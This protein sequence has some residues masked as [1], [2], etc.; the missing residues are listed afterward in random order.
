[1]MTGCLGQ[2]NY[3]SQYVDLAHH[4]QGATRILLGLSVMNRVTGAVKSTLRFLLLNLLNFIFIIS[5]TCIILVTWDRIGFLELTQE[6]ASLIF[7]AITVQIGIALTVMR[8]TWQAFRKVS[9]GIPRGQ[10]RLRTNLKAEDNPTIK[11]RA[12]ILWFLGFGTIFF[13][14]SI[15][16]HLFTLMGIGSVILQ[17]KPGPYTVENYRW[18]IFMAEWGSLFFIFGFFWSGYIYYVKEVFNFLA[19]RQS[20][21]FPDSHDA[22]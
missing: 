4:H 11:S 5:L 21:L 3:Q 22:T 12:I 1:M 2:Y 17:L 18:G 7:A 6:S 14:A 20:L 10:R 13:G 15:F 16:C 9:D 19:G 8:Y